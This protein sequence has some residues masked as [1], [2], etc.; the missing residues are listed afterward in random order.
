MKLNKSFLIGISVMVG[1]VACQSKFEEKSSDGLQVETSSKKEYVANSE[2][3]QNRISKAQDVIHGIKKFMDLVN[4]PNVGQVGVSDLVLEILESVK[5][6]HSKKTES[7][8]IS[9]GEV[10]ITT[11]GVSKECRII[12]T[13]SIYSKTEAKIDHN[14]SLMTC[15]TK[16][17]FVEIAKL[18]VVDSKVSFVVETNLNTV[19]PDLD[20]QKFLSVQNCDLERD[21]KEISKITCKASDLLINENEKIKFN[22]ISYD[23]S[24]DP[25]FLGKGVLYKND[26][27]KV[28]L[29]LEVDRQNKVTPKV[30]EYKGN[31]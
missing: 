3:I 24:R 26:V 17:Q 14:L 12:K 19:L 5:D 4:L 7:G 30:E 1:L 8:Y 18:D 22:E 9:D 20:L 16:G 15:K 21:D 11:P 2:D 13:R 6:S 27:P 23:R 31:K 25:L 28:Q 10:Y 29:T